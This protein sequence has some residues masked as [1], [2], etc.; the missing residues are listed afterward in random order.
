VIVDQHVQIG[1]LTT[2]CIGIDKQT[3]YH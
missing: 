3:C 1:L 2:S